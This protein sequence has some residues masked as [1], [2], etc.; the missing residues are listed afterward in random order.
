MAV[1]PT[2]GWSLLTRG[3]DK[4]LSWQ[5]RGYLEIKHGFAVQ[6]DV[7][8]P[9]LKGGGTGR[10]CWIW[11]RVSSCLHPP[12]S[13]AVGQKGPQ[14]PARATPRLSLG[15]GLGSELVT[16]WD[17]NA[18]PGGAA[19]PAPTWQ[20]LVEV[21]VRFLGMFSARLWGLQH[22]QVTEQPELGTKRDK[23]TSTGME[24]PLLPSCL[25]GIHFLGEK[26]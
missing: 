26:K 23:G 12:Q 6:G 2:S 14:S 15:A 21:P 9:Q 19:P 1:P 11:F 8:P 13:R 20:E 16:F 17:K 22:T 5:G 24:A 10:S 4:A 18:N 25:L 7:N 3:Q